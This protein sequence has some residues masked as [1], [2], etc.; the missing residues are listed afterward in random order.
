MMNIYRVSVNKNN[1]YRGMAFIDAESYYQAIKIAICHFDDVLD[2]K[3]KSASD[4]PI[5][6]SRKPMT[7]V[8]VQFIKDK[9]IPIGKIYP[10]DGELI[11]LVDEGKLKGDNN[12]E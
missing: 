9:G 7:L 2:V 1:R 10:E 6:S 8:G 4:I 5:V 11:M 3:V 12:N